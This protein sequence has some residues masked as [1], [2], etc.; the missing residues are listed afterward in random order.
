[1]FAPGR[2]SIVAAGA[3]VVLF[4][5]FVAFTHVAKR[6]GVACGCWGSL[7]DGPA[8][9]GELFRRYVLLALAVGV[10]AARIATPGPGVTPVVA[11]VLVA[12][13]AAIGVTLARRP[14]GGA[15]RVVVL[16]NVGAARELVAPDG[17]AA[18][19]RARRANPPRDT[20]RSRRRGGRQC[21]RRR[22]ALD[23]PRARVRVSPRR[24]PAAEHKTVVTVPG[25]EA[26][27]RIVVAGG[28]TVAAIG[29]SPD[30]MVVGA[31]GNATTTP[32]RSPG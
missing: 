25:E 31:H 14:S 1:M 22:P 24:T 3:S 28:R 27:L 10:F 4:A 29:E 16:A 6:R 20:R 12:G 23:W 11:G 26:S 21:A 8:G 7:S 18:R 30:A 13:A 17:R 32:K 9:R 5:S 2:A 19:G 15:A